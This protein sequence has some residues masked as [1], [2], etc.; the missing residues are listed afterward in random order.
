MGAGDRG[1]AADGEAV[2][3]GSAHIARDLM[4]AGLLVWST[5]GIALA[6]AIVVLS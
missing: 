1:R 4:L 3:P 2:I 5:I 6:V